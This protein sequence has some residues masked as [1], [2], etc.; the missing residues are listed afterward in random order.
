MP[1]ILPIVSLILQRLLLITYGLLGIGIIITIH[2]LGHFLFAKIFGVSIPSFSIGFGPR[3]IQKKYGETIFALSAIPL[4][5]YVEMAGVAEVGQGNQTEAHRN[6]N[7]SFTTK[8]YWQKLLI[9]IGGILFNII[10]SYSIFTCLFFL[11][12]PKN[13]LL[14]PFNAIPVIE[15]IAH[16]S[17]ASKAD[18][19]PDDHIIRL[20]DTPITSVEQLSHLV[21]P[22]AHKE[23][24]LLVT[25]Q[26]NQNSRKVTIIPD[27]RIV[28]NTAVGNLGVYF[29]QTDLPAVS[30]GKALIASSKM[31]FRLIK[32]TFFAFKSMFIKRSVEGLG[33][34]IMV[35]K[36]TVHGAQQGLKTFL[37]F[38]AFISINLAV[39]NIIPLP[40]LDGGQILF[41]TIEA[42]IQR[43]LPEQIKMYIH[44]VSWLFVLALALY[45][46]CKD[47]LYI[48]KTFK[49]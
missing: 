21:S 14:Y 30:W 4:G 45:L 40:I 19:H 32:Q 10:F 47:I 41:Y 26:G 44:Y 37:L 46:S 28:G 6:D 18:I 27:S 16:G 12:I 23:V 43:P 13:P 48:I 20:N 24:T 49:I 2:E 42:L 38:L 7:L 31:T 25:H 5:G 29:K 8:P 34:P 22:L 35:I 33:G 11:G 9:M 15:S 36:Q 3:I 39:L 17:A 1:S